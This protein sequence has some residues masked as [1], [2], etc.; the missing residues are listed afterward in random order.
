MVGPWE[1][2]GTRAGGKCA[3]KWAWGVRLLDSWSGTWANSPF[4]AVPLGAVVNLTAKK[5]KRDTQD[6]AA[7]HAAPIDKQASDAI[8]AKAA[9]ASTAQPAAGLAVSITTAVQQQNAV[10]TSADVLRLSG[11]ALSKTSATPAISKLGASGNILTSLDKAAQGDTYSAAA[12]A[13]TAVAKMSSGLAESPVGAV[14]DAVLL[15]TGNQKFAKTANQV[16]VS[17]VKALNPNAS[18]IQR[19]KAAF[20][21][22]VSAQGLANV[23]R[24]MGNAIVGLARF[25]LQR[26]SNVEKL[27]PM[28]GKLGRGA[29]KVAGSPLGRPIIWL[30]KWIPL[31]NVAGVALSAKEALDVFRNRQSSRTTKGLAVASI[32]TAVAGLVAGMT[33]GGWAFLAII[34]ASVAADVAL[35]AARKRDHATGDMDMQTRVWLHNPL[36]AA[37]DLAALIRRGVPKLGASLAGSASRTWQRLFGPKEPVAFNMRRSLTPLKG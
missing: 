33:L 13:Q 19:I 25:G 17:V 28:A 27:A 14:A 9:L 15:G 16:K 18:P 1:R 3:A 4:T 6:A 30:N 21:C 32:L 22:T 12:A 2:A 10:Q 8:S 5:D 35:A 20:D 34:G 29:A 26:A 7:A 31:L 36:R 24:A 37:S 23:G 11:E